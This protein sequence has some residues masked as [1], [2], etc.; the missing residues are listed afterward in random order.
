M[1]FCTDVVCG[2]YVALHSSGVWTIICCAQVWCVDS[3]L[4]YTACSRWLMLSRKVEISRRWRKN[5]F[6]VRSRTTVVYSL[7]NPIF[8]LQHSNAQTICNQSMASSSE[9]IDPHVKCMAFHFACITFIIPTGK[10]D[11]LGLFQW[12]LN[13]ITYVGSR[14]CR[15]RLAFQ[16]HIF[17]VGIAICIQTEILRHWLWIFLQEQAHL[18]ASQG[19]CRDW[20]QLTPEPRS[21]WAF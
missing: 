7:W 17:V 10:A 6:C 11:I 14:W 15:W 1:L 9:T 8:D 16:K 13:Y 4:L 20:R 2:K 21:F 5:L 19:G 3:K 18:E 12:I